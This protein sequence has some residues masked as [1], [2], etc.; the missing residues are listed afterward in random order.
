MNVDMVVANFI[1]YGIKRIFKKWGAFLLESLQKG[2]YYLAIYVGAPVLETP[3][4]Q[5]SGSIC[6]LWKLTLPGTL[7]WRPS[8]SQKARRQKLGAQYALFGWFLY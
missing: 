4:W 7:L 1:H 8:D 6:L 5:S 2:S 3:T